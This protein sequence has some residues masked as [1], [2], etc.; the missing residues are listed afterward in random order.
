MYFSSRSSPGTPTGS[1]AQAAVPHDAC[2]RA[3][4]V[5]YSL[6]L[7]RSPASEISFT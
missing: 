1:A 7:D 2:G 6:K 5:A 3:I 4:S